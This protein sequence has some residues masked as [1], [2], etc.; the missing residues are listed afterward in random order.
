M[1]KAEYFYDY[2]EDNLYLY[3]EKK[4]YG[5]I[6][7]GEDII[8]DFDKNLNIVA[9]EF[10]NASKILTMLTGKKITKKELGTI[11]ETDL[12]SERKGGLIIA[13]FKLVME[14]LSIEERLSLQD[15][16]YKS[17]ALAVCK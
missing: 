6:E 15:I 16:K 5:S 4:S 12:L 14:K 2:G 3:R 9:V 10:L 17:P 7:F 1:S 13:F 8:I 11:K